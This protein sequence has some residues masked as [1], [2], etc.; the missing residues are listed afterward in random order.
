MPFLFAFKFQDGM[1][2]DYYL[3]IGHAKMITMDKQ[4]AKL[5]IPDLPTVQ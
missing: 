1:V 3:L 4:C 5:M 2:A